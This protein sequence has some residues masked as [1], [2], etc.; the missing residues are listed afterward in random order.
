MVSLESPGSQLSSRYLQK[1][2]LDTIKFRKARVKILQRFVQPIEHI[3]FSS[4]A[5][6]LIFCWKHAGGFRLEYVK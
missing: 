2:F 1:I 6:C 3:V 4:S 5:S